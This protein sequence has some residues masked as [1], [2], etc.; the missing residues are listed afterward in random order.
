[1]ISILNAIPRTAAKRER[2]RQREKEGGKE[3]A[4]KLGAAVVPRPH[5]YVHTIG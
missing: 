4:S 5:T 1:M 2:E 3:N